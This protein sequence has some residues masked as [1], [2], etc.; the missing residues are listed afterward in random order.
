MLSTNIADQANWIFTVSDPNIRTMEFFVNEFSGMGMS[1]SDIS[2]N[3]YAGQI[4]KRPGDLITFG[5]L[6]LQVIMDE[7][8]D[9]LKEIIDFMQTIKNTQ[10]NVIDWNSSFTGILYAASNKNNFKKKFEFKHCWIR[11]LA[12]INF[13]S[14]TSAST[15][16]I[17]PVT[18]AY[19]TYSVSS[20]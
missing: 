13:M 4:V 6:N 18:V 20:I 19:D 10:T 11:D 9:S 5:D 1:L 17:V 3:E 8:F 15:P 12:D 2:P 7:N 16:V 14:T